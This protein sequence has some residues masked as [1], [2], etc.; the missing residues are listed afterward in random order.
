MGLMEGFSAAYELV[1]SDLHVLSEQ[2]RLY[3]TP[4]Q[5]CSP[6]AI[7]APINTLQGRTVFFCNEEFASRR[8]VLERMQY[9]SVM[10][11]VASDK[12]MFRLAFANKTPYAL[13]PTS[14]LDPYS[15]S[16]PPDIQQ[17]GLRALSF[18][19]MARS[20]CFP[21]FSVPSSTLSLPSFPLLLS[22]LFSRSFRHADHQHLR[23]CCSPFIALRSGGGEACRSQSAQLRSGQLGGSRRGES[24][25]FSLLSFSY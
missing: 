17:L 11:V 6:F 10:R 8:V 5:F 20:V 19:K 2:W 18:Y 22:S 7:V 13:P 23:H 14:F 9:L 3:D 21:M 15:I 25:S 24:P 12:S 4:L 16:Q 1:A